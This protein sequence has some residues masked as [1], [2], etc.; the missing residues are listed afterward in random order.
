MRSNMLRSQSVTVVCA[1]VACF[2]LPC[3]A[4][5][6]DSFSFAVIADPH[7]AGG[8]TAT[9]AQRLQQAVDWLNVHR[10]AEQIDMVFVVGDNGWSAGMSTAK[11]ILDT[12]QMPY[13]PM[14]G[15]NEIHAGD[16]TAFQNAYEP[17]FQSL[18]ALAA[19]PNSGFS[20][21][22]KAP[23]PVYVPSVDDTRYLQNYGFTYRGV[24]FAC[25]DWVKRDVSVGYAEDASLHDFAGGTLPW[26]GDYLESAQKDKLEN[27]VMLS[28][29]P[30]FTLGGQ[31]GVIAAAAGMFAPSEMAAIEALLLDPNQN[32]ADYVA[33]NFGG[34]LHSGGY[35]PE[36]ADPNLIELHLPLY[37][38]DP[39]DYDPNG[40]L[41]FLPLPGYDLYIVDDTHNDPHGQE[42]DPVRLNLVTVHE[43][44]DAFTYENRIIAVPEPASALLLSLA[45]V[46]VARRRRC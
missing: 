32:Y 23:G 34:H 16:D 20:A 15:D 39:N 43:Q 12:L 42:Y 24:N 46:V 25:L 8:P 35:C 9:S 26:L 5:T 6:G 19:D 33:L 40:P 7:I 27:T 18:E 30:M 11:N 22:D 31:L 10:Q 41:Q 38:F 45:G 2:A 37:E 44:A 4:A 36:N 21:W 1:S 28:H 13:A 17:V 14:M 3:L 29:H